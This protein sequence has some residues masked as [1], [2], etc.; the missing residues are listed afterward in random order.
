[1]LT[2]II[3]RS[4]R[5]DGWKKCVESLGKLPVETIFAD[6][7]PVFSEFAVTTDYVFYIYDNER[8]TPE[9]F[10][11]IPTFLYCDMFD[12]LTLYIR[13]QKELPD[14]CPRIFRNHV[15][16]KGDVL[17]PVNIELY[18]GEVI[19]NGWLEEIEEV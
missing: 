6:H 10:E 13:R 16:L 19:L 18:T 5:E 15:V 17:Y 2:A 1:M 11:A 4:G 3:L 8:L 9:L 7:G 12:Y 14:M